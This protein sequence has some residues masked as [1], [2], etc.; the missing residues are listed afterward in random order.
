MTDEAPDQSVRVSFA[1]GSVD[2]DL[3]AFFE[4]MERLDEV[5]SAAGVGEFD[6]N[7]D[8]E[9]IAYGPDAEALFAVMEP[10][11]RA[12]P[13]RPCTIELRAADDGEEDGAVLREF[14]L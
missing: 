1:E 4:L 9:L 5:I 11:L 13:A 3:P 2:D 6:G 12:F 14:L 10:L 8:E 7:M